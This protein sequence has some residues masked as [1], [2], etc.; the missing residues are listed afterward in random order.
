MESY[1]TTVVREGLAFGE[2]PRWHEGRLWFSDFYRHGIFSM[3]PDG[4]DER[5]E[6]DVDGQSSG[7]GWA[8][9]GSLLY[10]SMIDQQL[11]HFRDGVVTTFADISA[12]CVFWANEMLVTPAGFA[13]VGS[14]GYD[15]DVLLR[16]LGP[17]GFIAL[18]PPST[19]LIVVD[20]DGEVVQVVP[21]MD[22]PN[23][24]VV[25][26]DGST[27][28]VAETVARRLSAFSVNPDGTLRDR[29]VWAQFTGW[30]F[31]D[32]ICLDAEGQV[33][34]ANTIAPECKRVAEGGEV[35]AVATTSQNAFACALGGDD[36]RTLYAMTAP[37]SDRFVVADQRLG[38]VEAT[39]VDVSGA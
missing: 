38:K 25:T 8:G 14:F 26:P 1:E 19:N 35:T 30:T 15:L 31:P 12:H 22:F 29:R 24:T 23:G 37:S 3:A 16:D 21:E 7:L 28:I 17:A 36:G 9:D 5:V 4:S 27:L 34:L 33:W 10:V 32:G 6:V 13:Y 39:T 11:R 20:P 18:P 2:A